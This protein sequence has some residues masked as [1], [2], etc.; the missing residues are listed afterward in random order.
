MVSFKEL[1]K[2]IIKLRRNAN[3]TTAIKASS[4]LVK[5]R[6]DNLRLKQQNNY[7]NEKLKTNS[8][9]NTEE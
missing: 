1:Q 5:L 9:N 3:D 8:N 7:L 6:D 4:M 2:I